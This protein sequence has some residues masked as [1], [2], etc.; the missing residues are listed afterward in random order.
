MKRIYTYLLTRPNTWVLAI[1]TVVAFFY[2]QWIRGVLDANYA[3][4]K[5]PVPFFVQ[6]LSFS[7]E[8]MKAWYA[9]MVSQG[10]LGQYI[11]TQNIDSLF[12]LG[13]FALFVL[14]LTFLSRLFPAG[15]RSRKI[16]VGLALFSG[17]AAIF[18][19]CENLVS[20]IMLANPSGFPNV[21]A[22]VISSFSALKFGVFVATYLIAIISPVLALVLFIKR[23]MA[24]R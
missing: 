8:K 21:L 23:R 9:Y 6:Q 2:Q 11:H 7:P 4:S 12:I 16:M 10:T 24:T 14:G 13:T 22:Y 17:F 19:Q 3:A 15:S 1:T 5:F 18:D 20:Y